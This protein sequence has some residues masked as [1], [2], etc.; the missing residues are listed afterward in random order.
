MIQEGPPC[1]LVTLLYGGGWASEATGGNYDLVE[2]PVAIV[3]GSVCF[4][5]AACRL[6]KLM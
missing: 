3:Q 6:H 5:L 2:S 1:S 4:D